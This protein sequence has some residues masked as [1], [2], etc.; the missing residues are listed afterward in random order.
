[1]SHVK[2]KPSKHPGRLV[3]HKYSRKNF[4][5]T[6]GIILLLAFV[7]LIVVLSVIA[8]ALLPIFA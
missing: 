1:M 7:L 6:L 8:I 5:K 2:R 4:S 3:K